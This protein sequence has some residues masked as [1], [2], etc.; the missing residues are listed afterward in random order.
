MIE[1]PPMDAD[2][3][4]PECPVCHGA[5]TVNGETCDFCHGDGW[6]DPEDLERYLAAEEEANHE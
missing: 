2:R 5:R 3:E 1:P 4:P 6:V